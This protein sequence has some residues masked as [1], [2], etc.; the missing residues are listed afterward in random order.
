MNNSMKLWYQESGAK[1][2][3][4]L[5]VGNG[6]L[7]GMVFGHVEEERIQINE[8]TLWSGIPT[9]T[10]NKGAF[11][12]LQKARDLIWEEKYVEAQ[13]LIEEKMLGSWNESYQ[14][15]G[16]LILRDV[17]DGEVKN[18]YRDLDLE[19]AI[20]TTTFQKGDAIF[21]RE[22]FVSAVHQV[23]VIRITSNQSKSINLNVSMTSVHP[24]SFS[25][26]SETLILTG[27]S[28]SHVEP[29][30]VSHPDPVVYEEDKG[31]LFES[32]L[33]SRVNGGMVDINE[34]SEIEIRG[35]DEVTLYF[36]TATSFKGFDQDPSTDNGHMRKKCM[37]WLEGS[38]EINYNE[39]YA[40]HIKDYQYYFK[41]VELH[42]SGTPT[43]VLQLPTDQ[44]LDL[45][46]NG[47]YD[48]QFISLFFQYGRYLLI[49]SSR[50]GTQAANLQGIW[51]EK[52]RPPWS[53][54]Y[55]TNINVQMN[56]WLAEV[57]NLSE[58]H[59]PLFDLIE[60]IAISGRQTAQ[61][62]YQCRGWT[63]HHNV[64]LWRDTSPA[65]GSAKWAFWPMAGPWL[66]SH[67]WEHYLFTNDLNFLKQKALPLMEGAAQFLL[68]WLVEDEHGN[69]ISIPSTTPE[70]TFYTKEGQ[71]AYVSQ[72]S[73]MDNIFINELFTSCIRA[74]E[75]LGESPTMKTELEEALKKIPDFQIGKHGQLQEW[76]KDFDEPELGHRHVSH[77]YAVYPS[78]QISPRSTPE[79][80]EAAI[81]T[82]NRRL[83][84]G[85]G[86]T[87]WSCA[88]MISLW[89]RL[90][91]PDK[92]YEYL[93]TLFND[94]IYVNLFDI[95]PPLE[96][97]RDDVFQIDGNLGGTAGIAEMLLQTHDGIIE[98]LP[99]LPKQ[100][101][102]GHVKGLKAR[103][104]FE[105]DIFWSDNKV[106][107]AYI[108]SDTNGECRILAPNTLAFESE[109]L[110][111][112]ELQFTVESGKSYKLVGMLEESLNMS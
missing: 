67:L 95:H 29:N 53:S 84:N 31:M 85:G 78:N 68:D 43:S 98:F 13:E 52:I 26:D 36:A 55:T 62:Y 66:C 19:T 51:N 110:I 86:H 8:D 10:K 7:G 45:L 58:L 18:Y 42:L 30:Y 40:A 6:R 23:L 80:A 50:E 5:P 112:K 63:V 106:K 71:V 77:L 102:E 108:H 57:C 4:A 103:G 34:N 111:G 39:L 54:N 79:L 2:V 21:K 32:H 100:L 59:K 15:L 49:A 33:R 96:E 3:D 48:P 25:V 70:N 88:W 28:P 61:E 41:R 107:E 1:W 109:E 89:S 44:R 14:P 56:Y 11:E 75:I 91:R 81:T 47:G 35:A 99:G 74:Y 92:V 46:K 69:L 105:V 16:D 22:V 60:E 94:L 87:G 104:G 27:R 24:H 20:A 82:L 76:F 64:D 72:S 101:N 38:T 93:N 90:G 97:L 37:E 83:S 73:T 12:N 65:G 9:S 17:N